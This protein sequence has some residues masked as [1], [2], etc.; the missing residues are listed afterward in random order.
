VESDL[1]YIY[2]LDDEG[3]D[4]QFNRENKIISYDIPEEY[5]Y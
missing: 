5:L 1:Y 2:N 4:L 3:K